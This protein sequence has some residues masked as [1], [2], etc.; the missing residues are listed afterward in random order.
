MGPE[1][2][3]SGPIFACTLEEVGKEF[4]VTRERIRQIE[5]AFFVGTGN[6]AGLPKAS[7]R[8]KDFPR[9]G[10]Q[11][12]FDNS[13]GCDTINSYRPVGTGPKE[14]QKMRSWNY[15]LLCGAVCLAQL[16]CLSL[17]VW[18]AQNSAAF[19]RQTTLQQ[20][21]DDP[22][23]KSSGYYTYC[24][25][26]SGLGNEYWKNKTL[27]Q[28]MRPELVDDS[29]AA[30]NLVAENTRNG[31]QVTWQVYS[32]EEIAANSSLG[33]VQL[34][35]FPGKE[36]GGKYALV[37][38]GNGSTMTSEMEEGG[39]AAYQLHEQ[40]YTVFVLRYRTW[41]D[42]GDNAPI[43]DLANAV[44]FITAHAGQF[45]VQPENYALVGYSSGG[46]IAGIFANKERGYGSYQVERPGALLLGYPVVDLTVMKPLYHILYDIGTCGWRYYWANLCNMVDADYPPVYFWWGKNDV[47]LSSAEM[48]G[49]H[50]DF[51][52]TLE[53]NN[54][55]HQMVVYQNAPH[56]IGTGNGTDA[57]GWMTDAVAF[58]EAHTT[59]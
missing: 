49:Q 13:L 30:M 14:E 50:R 18:A 31:V 54:I 26:L 36:P 58:W 41:I 25:E 28:Y 20:L 44:K 39:S 9:P 52:R 29:V 10:P 40:G 24:R 45:G 15:K 7:L 42:M 19:T 5:G 32:P 11:N 17:P 48:P 47:V 33:C 46:Q 53:R 22:A 59:G 2:K 27:E 57:E 21:R 6:L 4:D 38:P 56:S 43:Q 23:I 12:C 37:V 1:T 8:E 34:Y 3:V 35:Y 55:P 51:D 16:A